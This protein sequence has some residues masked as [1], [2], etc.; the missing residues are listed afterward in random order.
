MRRLHKEPN[1][2][3]RRKKIF[4]F[5]YA[6]IVLFIVVAASVTSFIVVRNRL[7]A[8]SPLPLNFAFD[9][10]GPIT[11]FSIERILKK[12]NIAFVK[13]AEASESAFFITLPN[14]TQVVM[15]KQKNI[16]RQVSSLQFI[17]KRLT[18]EGK[19]IKNIDLRF[20]SPVVVFN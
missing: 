3:I 5:W 17:L 7:S 12:K 20:D 18:I 19:A 2:K 9:T 15:T 16:E 10:K 4:F 14:S 11:T 13:V 6:V 1:R 8:I